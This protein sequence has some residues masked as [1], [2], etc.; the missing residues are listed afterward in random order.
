M[1][2]ISIRTDDFVHDTLGVDLPTEERESPEGLDIDREKLAKVFVTH[3]Q[4]E[5]LL[6]L[7]LDVK[8]TSMHTTRGE[9]ETGIYMICNRFD[10][11]PIGANAPEMD[12]EEAKSKG[13][14]DSEAN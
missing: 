14:W 3:K 6:G 2:D 9:E 1:D 8:I 5:A 7:P 11:I 12:I 10:H 4:I 13:L